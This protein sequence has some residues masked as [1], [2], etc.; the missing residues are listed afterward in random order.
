VNVNN[1]H[2]YEVRIFATS[3]DANVVF[4]AIS[5][6]SATI[7]YTRQL[8]GRDVMKSGGMTWD[9]FRAYVESQPQYATLLTEMNR[10]GA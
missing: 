10:V 7:E 2:T 5:F 3:L 6:V 4:S 9:G 8:K 1:E